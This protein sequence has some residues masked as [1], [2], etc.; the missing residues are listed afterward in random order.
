MYAIGIVL[1]PYY[2]AKA[3]LRK[4]DNFC[5]KKPPKTG[6]KYTDFTEPVSLQPIKDYSKKAGI[7][8]NTFLMSALCGAIRRYMAKHNES[9][10]EI[11]MCMPFSL[12]PMPTDGSRLP[13]SNN[14][15]FLIWR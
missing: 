4:S 3:L 14:L 9:L 6:I 11:T 13:L 10:D 5:L 7:T 12:R 8:L 2:A 15:S 1:S